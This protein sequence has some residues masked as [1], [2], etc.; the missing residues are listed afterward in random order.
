M[1]KIDFKNEPDTTTPLDAENLNKLQDNIE[2][3]IKDK[4]G[5]KEL[6]GTTAK[7]INAND[8][9]A[10]GVY[11][12]SGE[13]T[14]FFD[15]RTAAFILYVTW[16]GEKLIQSV[17]LEEGLYSRSATCT[18]AGE[19]ISWNFSEWKFRG[20]RKEVGYTDEELE[21]T[22][23]ILI[24]DG[25]FDG[26]EPLGVVE[27]T[28]GTWKPQ[29]A[30]PNN[31]SAPTVTYSLQ[32]G[33][34]VKIGKLIFVEFGIRGKITALNGTNNYASIIGLPE[35]SKIYSISSNG[36]PAITLGNV[37][38]AFE[39]EVN[40]ASF[41]TKAGIRLQNN[42]GSSAAKWKITNNVDNYFEVFGSGI[43]T[44]EEE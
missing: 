39:S 15:D 42:H 4:Q 21:G 40:L 32:T 9:K 8:I 34:Y 44:L 37:Y 13:H 41:V 7:P 30:C 26:V 16:D 33:K 22:E 27:I 31:E 17:I 1:E 29:I 6:L 3:E 35:Q 28:S 2:K 18:I 23:K 5:V 19:E 24:E 12:I 38:G 20:G 36:A 14:N 10:I 11:R 25:D 43:Y